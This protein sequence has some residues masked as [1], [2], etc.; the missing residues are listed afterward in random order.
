[1]MVAYFYLFLA[2]A[3]NFLNAHCLEALFA[4]GLYGL[5]R[6]LGKWKEV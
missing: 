4:L 3:T 1:M 2:V 5:A 6:Y